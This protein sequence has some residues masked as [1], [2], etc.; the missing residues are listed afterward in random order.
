MSSHSS[1]SWGIVFT[2]QKA[3]QTHSPQSAL[4]IPLLRRS[5]S[6]VLHS[7]LQGERQTRNR[8]ALVPPHPRNGLDSGS[9]PALQFRK[10]WRLYTVQE[11]RRT[12][13]LESSSSS[14]AGFRRRSPPLHHGTA[15][16]CWR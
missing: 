12:C 5:V 2:S 16:R 10:A 14:T 11:H 8:L 4:P 7:T 6:P 1:I 13:S 15:A 9:S 3:S